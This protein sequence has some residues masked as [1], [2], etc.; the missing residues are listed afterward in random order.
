VVQV[1]G[2]IA[3]EGGVNDHLSVDPEHETITK[4]FFLVPLLSQIGDWVS[5]DFSDVLNDKLIFLESLAC[6][7]TWSS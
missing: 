6:E 4:A 2:L 5:N 1:S 3:S 7:E